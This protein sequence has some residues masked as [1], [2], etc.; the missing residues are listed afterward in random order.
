MLGMAGM[1]ARTLDRVEIVARALAGHRLHEALFRMYERRSQHAAQREDL[2]RTLTAVDVGTT[3]D[4][5]AA[6][7]GC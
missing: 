1:L 7:V 3:V 5:A 6:A 4:G 2:A